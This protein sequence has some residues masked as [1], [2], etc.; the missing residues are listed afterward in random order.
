MNQFELLLLL[1]CDLPLKHAASV[2]L[3]LE[4]H[5]MTANDGLLWQLRE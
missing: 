4:Y 5:W 2:A 3:W 1:Q